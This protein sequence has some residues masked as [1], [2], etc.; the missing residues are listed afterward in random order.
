MAEESGTD[1]KFWDSGV[2]NKFCDTR[3]RVIDHTGNEKTLYTSSYVLSQSEYFRNMLKSGTSESQKKDG[4]YEIIIKDRDPNLMSCLIKYM[5][6]HNKEASFG[7]CVSLDL[8]EIYR[9][10]DMYLMSDLRTWVRQKIVDTC[11]LIN[12]NSDI[13]EINFIKQCLLLAKQYNLEDI[14]FIISNKHIY[15]SRGNDSPVLIEID[16]EIMKNRGVMELYCNNSKDRSQSSINN[17]GACEI[18]LRLGTTYKKDDVPDFYELFEKVQKNL[19]ELITDIALDYVN[20]NSV[21]R[22]FILKGIVTY[23][24]IIKRYEKKIPTKMRKLM[25]N[26]YFFLIGQSTIPDEIHNDYSE[27]YNSCF[28]KE[29]DQI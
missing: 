7:G 23:L 28:D 22:I 20:D 21:K 4:Y 9:M 12:K 14:F 13:G 3:I 10:S 27:M 11:K 26:T 19:A 15:Y 2:E 5:M 8:P 16:A 17:Y 18:M 6:C 25:R 24:C 29:K 1:I